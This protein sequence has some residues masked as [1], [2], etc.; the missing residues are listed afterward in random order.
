MEFRKIADIAEYVKNG[1]ECGRLTQGAYRKKG[2]FRAVRG[3]VGERVV[4]V[5]ADGLT[6]TENTVTA[7][8]GYPAAPQ[9]TSLSVPSPPQAYR[10]TASPVS[11][12][13]RAIRVQ[14]PGHWDTWIR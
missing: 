6:E 7:A 8:L 2:E 12:A 11:A 4:T 13:S 10:R 14:S 9:A 1:L 3:T 5:M